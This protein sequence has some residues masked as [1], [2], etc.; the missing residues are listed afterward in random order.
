MPSV[1]NFDGD[2]ARTAF[3]VFVFQVTTASGGTVAGLRLS[4]DATESDTVAP[5]ARMAARTSSGLIRTFPL[6]ASPFPTRS[7][8]RREGDRVRRAARQAQQHGPRTRRRRRSR[9]RLPERRSSV[10]GGLVSPP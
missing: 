7:P 2:E 4:A 9:S 1:W 6:I 3:T 8:R 5:T 10:R